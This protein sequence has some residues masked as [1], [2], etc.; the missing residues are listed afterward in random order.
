MLYL[1]AAPSALEEELSRAPAFL[2][3]HCQSFIPSFPT[4]TA[5]WLLHPRYSC[6]LRRLISLER[7][8]VFP[9]YPMGPSVM[10]TSLWVWLC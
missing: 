5:P 3:P 7:F 8:L 1:L 2:F 4:A 6:C 10:L 9:F